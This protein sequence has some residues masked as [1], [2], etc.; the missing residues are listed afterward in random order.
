MAASIEDLKTAM[1]S[2][3]EQRHR[4]PGHGEAVRGI[5]EGHGDYA[6]RAQRLASVAD[7]RGD[8]HGFDDPA[9]EGYHNPGATVGG[10][11]PPTA[12]ASTTA[13]VGAASPTSANRDAAPAST[14][15]DAD[16]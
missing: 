5:P 2:M 12:S 1:D 6:R 8:E 16:V 11:S 14:L 10:A 3:A 13:R 9:V 7:D 4:C 15:A